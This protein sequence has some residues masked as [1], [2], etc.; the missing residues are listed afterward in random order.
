M[1]YS[2]P[3]GNFNVRLIQFVQDLYGNGIG[4]SGFY[5]FYIFES[6]FI[7]IETKQTES[8]VSFFREPCSMFLSVYQTIGAG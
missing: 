7:M 5:G 4:E 1:N 2:S 3:I 8:N 6:C